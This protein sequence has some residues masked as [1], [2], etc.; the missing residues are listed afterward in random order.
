MTVAVRWVGK[1]EELHLVWLYF[2]FL[3]FF[4]LLREIKSTLFLSSP[5][6][7]QKRTT[8]CPWWRTTATTAALSSQ[9]PW[10]HHTNPWITS[11]AQDE[12]SSTRPFSAPLHRASSG[13]AS[14]ALPRRWE[15]MFFIHSNYCSIRQIS[16]GVW[17]WAKHALGYIHAYLVKSKEIDESIRLRENPRIRL[18]LQITKSSSA[19]AFYTNRIKENRNQTTHSTLEWVLIFYF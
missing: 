14:S 7:L 18:Y 2:L 8:P 15:E 4:L 16:W 11:A 9:G 10:L 3:S 1:V 13:R 19:S 12:V 5:A 17:I 6:R